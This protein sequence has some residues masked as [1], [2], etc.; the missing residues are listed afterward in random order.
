VI[1]RQKLK[2]L[3]AETVAAMLKDD[4]LELAFLQL[5]SLTNL[6]ALGEMIPRDAADATAPDIAEQGG[7]GAAGSPSV[8]H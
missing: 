3:N 1:D 2:A 8:K 4:E 6:R 5:H 7:F